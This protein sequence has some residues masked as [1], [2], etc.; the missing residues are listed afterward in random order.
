[1][2]QGMQP[3]RCPSSRRVHTLARKP[4]GWAWV[5]VSAHTALSEIRR[6]GRKGLAFTS[7]HF[8]RLPVD[9][10]SSLLRNGRSCE[11]RWGELSLPSHR[12]GHSR[13]PW[14][15]SKGLK[16][17]CGWTRWDLDSDE[18]QPPLGDP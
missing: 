9:C 12:D 16:P 5:S 7:A 17:G 18:K 14:T 3:P 13:S 2:A 15:P 6:T 4:Q 10:A 11:R 1:M 8:P